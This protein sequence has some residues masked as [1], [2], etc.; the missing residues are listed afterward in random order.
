MARAGRRLDGKHVNL[1][2]VVIEV[3]CYIFVPV[4]DWTRP[5]QA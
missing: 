4:L 2:R 3:I 1:S 5:D